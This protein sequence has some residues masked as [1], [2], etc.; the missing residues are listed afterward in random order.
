MEITRGV[1]SQ[2]IGGLVGARFV[3]G[4]RAVAAILPVEPGFDDAYEKLLCEYIRVEE[5]A[6]A[7]GRAGASVGGAWTWEGRQLEN[8]IAEL[9]GRLDLETTARQIYGEFKER[10]RAEAERLRAQL[11][12]RV[13]AVGGDA[14]QAPL[15]ADPSAAEA[16]P[17]DPDS[18]I[19]GGCNTPK[20]VLVTAPDSEH[21]AGI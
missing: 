7:A 5:A 18:A 8:Y 12:E 17:S 1:F 20:P 15:S 19:D 16:A 4:G 9:D 6:I 13:K 11:G 21:P 2:G 14:A 3:P 10:F